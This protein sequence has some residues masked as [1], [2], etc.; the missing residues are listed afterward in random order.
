MQSLVYNK[1]DSADLSQENDQSQNLRVDIRYLENKLD[2][3]NRQDSCCL[4]FNYSTTRIEFCSKAIK[5]LLGFK[6]ESYS[7]SHFL[8]IIHPEDALTYLPEEFKIVELLKELPED[9]RRKC[10][11][12]RTFRLKHANGKYVRVLQEMVVMPNDAG[13]ECLRVFMGL[14]RAES[15]EQIDGFKMS[16]SNVHSIKRPTV[17]NSKDECQTGNLSARER[18]ILA[19]LIKNMSTKEIA[20]SLSRSPH[21]IKNHRKN[22]LRKTGAT[23]T[24]E[25]VMQ[26][27]QNDW[28]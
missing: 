21:T 14:S 26:A 12:S 1:S 13:D 3:P 7:V 5:G 23:S 9:Q 20:E 4:V 19:L 28:V 11:V 6:P 25:L 8:R 24:L 17:Q 18:E 15:D 2:L 10:K 16:L 22:M 27:V